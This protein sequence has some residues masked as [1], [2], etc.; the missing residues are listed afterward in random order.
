VPRLSHIALAAALLGA[1]IPV[2]ILLVDYLSPHGYWA[3]W[4]LVVWPTSF[5]LIATSAIRDAFF[6][7]VAAIST[8][9]NAALYALFAV[10]LVALCRRIA[11]VPP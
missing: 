8:I 6:L 3:N 5:M 4:I 2:A 9:I 7:E 1:V 11:R 10:L